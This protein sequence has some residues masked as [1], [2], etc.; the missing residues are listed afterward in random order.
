MKVKTKIIDD[1][2]CEKKTTKKGKP[3]N[4]PFKTSETKSNA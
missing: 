4:H 3:S 2:K 1:K